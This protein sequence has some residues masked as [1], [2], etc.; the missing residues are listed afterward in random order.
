MAKTCPSPEGFLLQAIAME[1][2]KVRRGEMASLRTEAPAP[3][4]ILAW[5]FL[6]HSFDVGFHLVVDGTQAPP[7]R[8]QAADE[9]VGGSLENASAVEF[10]WDN[11]YSRLRS[12][13]VSFRYCWTTASALHAA[14]EAANEYRIKYS[15]DVYRARA[16]SVVDRPLTLVSDP[17]PIES[18][19]SLLHRLEI[20]VVDTVTLFMAQPDVP[21]HA[22]SA[23]DLVLALEAIL[24]HG[25]HIAATDVYDVWPEEAYFG[26]LVQTQHVLR[27]DNH[28][29]A[30]AQLFAPPTHLRYLG[31]GRA[32][33]FLFYA[34]NR[35]VLPRALE[36]LTKREGLVATYYD[37]DIAFLGSYARAKQAIALLAALHGVS[38]GLA[39]LVDDAHTTFTTF[40]PTLYMEH[41][42]APFPTSEVV[43][44]NGVHG[45][46]L[47]FVGSA[48][49]EAFETINECTP[50]RYLLVGVSAVD[51][52]VPRGGVHPIALFPAEATD[53]DDVVVVAMQVRADGTADI[54]VV[55]QCHG[56]AVGPQL[57]VT[58]SAHWTEL[59]LRFEPPRARALTLLFDNRDTMM[60]S[61]RV[62][63]RLR[64]VTYAEYAQAW[65]ATADMAKA[66]CWKHVIQQALHST[67]ALVAQVRAHEER[68]LLEQR[69]SLPPP[70]HEAS[71]SEML[72]A[73]WLGVRS[74]A[75]CGQCLELFSLFR[76]AQQCP[77]CLKQCCANCTRH[78]M[79]V[80]RTGESGYVCDR[81]YLKALDAELAARQTRNNGR[82]ENAALE[83]LRQNPSM[84]KYFKMLSFGVPASAI[85]QKMQQ[86]YIDADI[87][88]VF[89]SAL[90][91]QAAP[92][93]GEPRQGAVPSA[94]LQRKRSNLRKL[95]WTALD[96]KKVDVHASIWHRQTDKRRKAPMTLSSSDMDRL[97][98]L[99]GDA[100]RAKS[101]KR[102]AKASFSALDARRSNNINIAL[103]R[104]KAVAGGV[105]GVVAALAAC[106]LTVLTQD[107][108]Q[109]LD[110]TAPTPAETKR[111]ADFRG[112]VTDAAESFL[113][114][115]VR[116]PRIAE[117]IK[118]MLYVQQ[119]AGLAAALRTQLQS[120]A[121]A[122]RD[123]LRSER[124]PRYFEII[125]ALGNVL[126]EG[127]EHADASGVTLS[128]L[129]KLSET[130]STDQ[131]ITLLQYLIQLIHSRGEADLFEL[132]NEFAALEQARRY[133]NVLCQSQLAQL[134]KGLANL[135]YEIKE[136]RLHEHVI[137]ERAQRQRQRQARNALVRQNSAA[138]V[139]ERQALLSAIRRQASTI[140]AIQ[141]DPEPLPRQ[142]L[143]AAIRQ[144]SPAA[145][146]DSGDTKAPQE[147]PPPGRQ[148]LL[149]A[150]RQR[151]PDA[152]TAAAAPRDKVMPGR[153]AL[154]AAIQSRGK[155]RTDDV[156]VAP[157]PPAD[158]RAALF[159]AI[160]KQPS[161][162]TTEH[163]D[164][165][166]DARAAVM[167]ALR[168]GRSDALPPRAAL[169]SAVRGEEPSDR[170]A[171]LAAIRK[172]TA[173]P[174]APEPAPPATEIALPFVVVMEAQAC[175]IAEDLARLQDDVGV[176]NEVWHQAAVYLGEGPASS[177]D[178]V[179]GLLHRFIMDVKLALRLLAAKGL[180]PPAN[181][182][183]APASVGNSVATVFGPGVV[184]AVR[185]GGAQLEVR[186]PWAATG[187]L[188]PLSIIHPS[189]YVMC[190]QFGVGIVTETHYARG[191]L[192]VRFPF[193][194]GVVRVDDIV[195]KLPTGSRSSSKLKMRMG[196]PIQTPFGRATLQSAKPTGLCYGDTSA[197]VD[198]FSC[199]LGHLY[200]QSEHAAFAF[201]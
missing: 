84:D 71:Y 116:Q 174:A 192:Q 144:R 143:L 151:S 195:Y 14:R 172:E 111:Y 66:M 40:P 145:E 164:S 86:D 166:A 78:S 99:F 149:A 51:A 162:T 93:G 38:F 197:I 61:K 69:P 73:S 91:P 200:L 75:A 5:Q 96:T 70:E 58:A 25:L 106:D 146:A 100:S 104:F 135:K 57:R 12:K 121:V 173:L 45:D 182:L 28:V 60:W 176:L 72:L 108:L 36:N 85:G 123:V 168:K 184:V 181:A 15:N 165:E 185:H 95:H 94:A 39:P 156:F 193:G 54:G 102:A 7:M 118:S 139:P 30:D 64:A 196:D 157:S 18:H 169:L 175:T 42:H 65:Q 113:V 158:P 49:S 41:A 90:A 34:L 2:T 80:P 74:D 194:Y 186:F 98:E 137:R 117:K 155:E 189:N 114:D 154:L 201:E 119:Y 127:T 188:H 46:L 31:W 141:E 105:A 133:S 129:L 59:L 115:L 153:Q 10:V 191:M 68:T 128:S 27:D 183:S 134:Q 152:E 81:C 150:I 110:E 21:L 130:R 88:E 171:L 24:R 160:R 76:R 52:A 53:A 77:V 4:R 112:K 136:E 131:S 120:I 35:Q 177:S 161:A 67:D 32:R 82:G 159:A 107:V 1:K 142:A 122:A 50:V 140:D 56:I 148:A 33:A 147:T 132:V 26:F 125:L 47:Q 170:N 109:T 179:F 16:A 163:D 29:V 11:R 83:A 178:Y 20:A 167:G 103:S 199:S 97:V 3:G 124:L 62:Q 180:V 22:G 8:V 48:A 37:V 101:L 187:L 13:E 43:F 89:T 17:Q 79:L 9:V 19:D 198:A 23:R 44:S 92:R 6:V 87:I 190:R 63:Y 55:V 126:N 138:P